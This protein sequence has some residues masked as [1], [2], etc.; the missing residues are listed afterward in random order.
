VLIGEIRDQETAKTAIQAA[1]TGH[2][3]LASI[4]ANDT[5]ST[6][7]R[8]LE[9]DIDEYLISSTLIGV[10]SQ[11]MVRR[12]CTYCKTETEP[13][14]EE[15][16]IFEETMQ[17]KAP[18]LY[19]GS[20]CQFCSHT[21]YFNRTGVFELM[22]MNEDIRDAVRRH[23]NYDEIKDIAIKK[24]LNTLLRDGMLKVKSGETTVAE[25]MRC[26]YSVAF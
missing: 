2:L 26:L 9:L 4:H 22:M 14:S 5:V 16:A 7:F 24:G 6:L 10:L 1:L 8:L 19:H 15:V 17:E 21:G 25:V 3:L 11:R 23:S 20:G 12:I 18:V 13:N